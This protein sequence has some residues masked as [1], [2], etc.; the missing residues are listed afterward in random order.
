MNLNPTTSMA[1]PH[2]RRRLLRARSRIP[3]PALFLDRDGVLIE[4]KHYLCDPA[5][6]V[7]CAG[8]KELV[9]AAHQRNWAVVVITNQSGIARGYFD[10]SDYEDVTD[11][12][13][14]SLGTSTPLAGI[15]ANGHGPEA[16]AES[17]RKP[18][19]AMLLEASRELNLDLNKSILVGDRLTDLQA[20]ARAGVQTLVHVLSGHGQEERNLINAWVAQQN[21]ACSQDRRN[22]LYCLDNLIKF[23]TSLFSRCT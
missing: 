6:V 13:L 15:Y 21:E 10:W 23:P 22:N 4:D 17:W 9:K 1:G 11:R 14:R 12:M 7:L 19:P 18:S 2:E 3:T 8:S 20:G 16:P 5:E